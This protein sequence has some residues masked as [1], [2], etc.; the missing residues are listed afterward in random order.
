MKKII[1]LFT[2]LISVII[3]S[4]ASSKLNNGQNNPVSVENPP[5]LIGA[6]PIPDGTWRKYIKSDIKW[7]TSN[8]NGL[9]T[10]IQTTGNSLWQPILGYV[11][12]TNLR[13]L[14]INGVSYD[15]SANRIWNISFTSLTD[16][17]TS[18]S[19][20]GIT[21]AYPLVGNPSGFLTSVPFQSWDSI[22][23]KP[24]F[25]SVATSGDYT[26]LINKPTIYSFTGLA[27]QYTKGDG[28]Y[29]I[30]PTS[31]SNFTNDT[32]FIDQS[33]LILGL[34]SK[35]NSISLGTVSQYWRGDKS[36][37][38]LDRTAIG[39]SNV[40]NTSDLLKPIS[41]ATQTAL[42]TKQATLVTGTNIKTING[43]SIL[44]S[45]DIVT[46]TIPS[47][48]AGGDLTGTY[49]NPIL[50]STGVTAGTYGLVV[51]DAKGRVTGGKRQIAYS[52]VTDASGNYTVTFSTPF[53]VPPNIQ[54][55]VIGGNY[56]YRKIT[57]VTTTGFTVNVSAQNTTVVATISV[58]GVGV[59][60]V[61]NANVD[62]LITEK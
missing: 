28:T 9:S 25:A 23:G 31:L 11:P 48:S 51:V 2:F 16:K 15:L 61:S 22:T 26:D 42:N 57:N 12:V 13:T 30:F 14:N 35:E 29:G 39:L 17:P 3:Y 19:G 18:L 8:I 62:V 37:Q 54:V 60:V 47:G 10:F 43:L 33:E 41:T 20:Y 55:N 56:L 52:G 53:S 38:S 1:T 34:S 40:D 50:S 4:Q 49:P 32:G 46:S 24:N 27:S 45:G 44:G 59:S 6:D 5:F 7:E 21:D 36:W 58:I